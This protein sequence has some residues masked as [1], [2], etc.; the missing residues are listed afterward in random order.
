MGRIGNKGP[1][2]ERGSLKPNGCLGGEEKRVLKEKARWCRGGRKIR[3]VLR[4]EGE[5]KKALAMR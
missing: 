1:Q 2:R 5:G 4:E 3:G